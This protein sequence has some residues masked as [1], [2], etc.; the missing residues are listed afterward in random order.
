MSAHAL[1]IR[2]TYTSHTHYIRFT[3]VK[4]YVAYA[5]GAQI[6]SNHIYFACALHMFCMPKTL[7]IMYVYPPSQA[8]DESLE[9]FWD[10]VQVSVPFWSFEK[11]TTFL[12]QNSVIASFWFKA[13]SIHGQ[14]KAFLEQQQH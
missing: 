11:R 10:S 4:L 8:I 14:R 5:F 9:D 12:V 7:R 2:C 6:S 3:N 13:H 1:H